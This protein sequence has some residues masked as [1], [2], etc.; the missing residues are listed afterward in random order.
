MNRFIRRVVSLVISLAI[1]AAL[2]LP[3]SVAVSAS[4][5]AS[6]TINAPNTNINLH[7]N[8]FTA[9][10]ILNVTIDSSE[11]IYYTVNSDFQAFE[12]YLDSACK[13]NKLTV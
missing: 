10:R 5:D 2:A 13:F 12:N 11:G 8:F 6:I 7:F 9:Y 4:N 3:L 1:L